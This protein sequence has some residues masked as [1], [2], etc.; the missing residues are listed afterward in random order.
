MTCV[1]N[2]I[3][4]FFP[5]N[6]SGLPGGLDGRQ[7][8][9]LLQARQSRVWGGNRLSLFL[10]VTK[11]HKTSKSIAIWILMRITQIFSWLW[12]VTDLKLNPKQKSHEPLNASS[13]HWFF[14]QKWF[15]C[16]QLQLWGH[17]YSCPPMCG[18]R[19]AIWWLPGASEVVELGMGKGRPG[20]AFNL[21]Y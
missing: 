21:G 10:G 9:L 1:Q 17:Q 4:G 7:K 2:C 5:K 11:H 6:C 18:P 12:F 19:R 16:Q 13:N 14:Q 3:L 8:G 15:C 20:K